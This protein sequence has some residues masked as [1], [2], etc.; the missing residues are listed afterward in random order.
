V[1]VVL[2]DHSY[3]VLSALRLL[4]EQEIGAEVVGEVRDSEALAAAVGHVDP[5][6]VLLDWSLPESGGAGAVA[7]LRTGQTSRGI[8]ALSRDPEDRMAAMEAGV[9]GFL[10]KGE[11][12]ELLVALVRRVFARTQETAESVDTKEES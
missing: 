10:S 11:S 4:F 12:P 3:E 7:R 2:A 9:D 1:R 5:D 6:V 8:I